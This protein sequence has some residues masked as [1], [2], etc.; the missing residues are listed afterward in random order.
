M[1]SRDDD[2]VASASFASDIESSVHAAR[3]PV[4]GIAVRLSP[5]SGIERG[6]TPVTSSESR[7]AASRQAMPTSQP[8]RAASF[9]H[10]GKDAAR[11]RVGP[12][13]IRALPPSTAHAAI[14]SASSH[15]SP[16]TPARSSP[17]PAS[18]STIARTPARA[19][20]HAGKVPPCE[21][22]TTTA[23]RSAAASLVWRNRGRGC[24]PWAFGSSGRLRDGALFG[25][26]YP[27]SRATG[28]D[29]RRS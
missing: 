7:R 28:G 13:P 12:S 17:R 26:H 18:F 1:R 29:R 15:A 3:W 24:F 11:E 25:R 2:R 21:P 16:A 20:S 6:S 19:A 27:A 14:P 22:Q 23:P 8:A 4:F 5:R 9:V 10:G